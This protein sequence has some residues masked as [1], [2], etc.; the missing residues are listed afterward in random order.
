[1][2]TEFCGCVTE[3]ILSTLLYGDEMWL[4]TV[5]LVERLRITDDREAD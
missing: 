5:M 4:I 1:L 3:I 2:Q